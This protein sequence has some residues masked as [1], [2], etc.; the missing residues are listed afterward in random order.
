MT[1][2]DRMAQGWIEEKVREG[3][4]AITKGYG[5]LYPSVWIAPDKEPE[6][7]WWVTC[8][9]DAEDQVQALVRLRRE[10][11]AFAAEWRKDIKPGGLLERL[12]ALTCPE[13]LGYDSWDDCRCKGEECVPV[14]ALR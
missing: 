5:P 3:V 4:Q 7:G 6:R 9:F 8:A 13:C 10:A 11:E 14:E 12:G 1:L 2:G